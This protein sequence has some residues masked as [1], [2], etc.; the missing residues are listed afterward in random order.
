MLRIIVAFG[1]EY[2][3]LGER[4][5]KMRNQEVKAQLFTAQ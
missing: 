1:K 5:E 3:K 4:Q 2:F